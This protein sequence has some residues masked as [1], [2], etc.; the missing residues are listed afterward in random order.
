[1]RYE[2]RRQHEIGREKAPT[3]KRRDFAETEGRAPDAGALQH[4]GRM[5]SC[6]GPSPRE[7]IQLRC[8]ADPGPAGACEA[9]QNSFEGEGAQAIIGASHVARHVQP[10]GKFLARRFGRVA[11]AV[12]ECQLEDIRQHNSVDDCGRSKIVSVNVHE[13]EP[14]CNLGQR[15]HHSLAPHEVSKGF[16]P[17]AF[18]Y[19]D[20]LLM[21]C[22]TPIVGTR[23]VYRMIILVDSGAA[24]R[25]V[26]VEV[27]VVADPEREHRVHTVK[28][29]N[30]DIAP[31]ARAADP[32]LIPSG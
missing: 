5:G 29:G 11:G 31:I 21:K 2:Y 30:A 24:R 6:R 22:Q 3:E 14:P 26:F 19:L 23:I 4:F 16:A 7:E 10:R 32:L 15:T 18:L 8:G 12:D 13:R 25:D 1:M 20:H 9:Q 17:A 28:I 27:N